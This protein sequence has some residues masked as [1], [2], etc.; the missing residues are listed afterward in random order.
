MQQMLLPCAH[1]AGDKKSV[2]QSKSINISSWLAKAFRHIQHRI[3]M[4]QY[5]KGDFFPHYFQIFSYVHVCILALTG[6]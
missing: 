5:K 3:F 2:C 4:Y 1:T 6:S